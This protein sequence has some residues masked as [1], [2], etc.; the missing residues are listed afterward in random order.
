MPPCQNNG[1]PIA[2][3]PEIN[4]SSPNFTATPVHERLGVCFH[5]SALEFDATVEHILHS[6]SPVSYHCLIGPD[7]ARCT[8]VADE[9]IAW[10]AGASMFLG[11]TRCNDFL[12]G[13]SFAGNTY[14]A[15]LTAAQTASALDWL[16][17][18]WS[19]HGWTPA[20]MTDHRQIAPGRKDDLN[21]AEWARLHAAI[22]EQFAPGGTVG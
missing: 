15:P 7:G 2:R 9:R 6:D 16:A 18:R 14:L 1:V 4:C 3:F 8:F 5:H 19:L 12:L 21:P 13:V 17:P 22:V 11:R 20:R 10:H